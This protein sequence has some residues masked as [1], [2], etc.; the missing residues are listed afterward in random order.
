M[1]F[2]CAGLT[3][4]QAY[5]VCAIAVGLV[6]DLARSLEKKIQ[7]FCNEIMTALVQSLQNPDLHRSVKPPVLSCFGDIAMAIE[8]D[9]EPYLQISMMMLMQASA[10]PI[11][12]D[13]DEFYDFVNQLRESVLEAYTGIVQGLKDGNRI[14]L[15]GQYVG[16]VMSFLET[17]AS[18]DTKDPNVMS[19]AAGLL[20]DIASALGKSA[21]EPLSKPFV[22]A[23]L[24][25][26]YNIGDDSAKETCNWARNV[27]QTV[28]Q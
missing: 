5:H 13:D 27:I 18:E 7:P 26:C 17:L 6:G 12:D 4:Y 22:Y 8:S 15:F 25:E 2:L 19:K 16:P 14:V 1:P 11:P 24:A 10:T 23:M 28:V 21:K 9:F 20:G 3:N